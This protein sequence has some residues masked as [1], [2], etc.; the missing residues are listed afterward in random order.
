MLKSLSLK[1]FKC[2]ESLH[3]P[4]APL[5]ML[6]GTNASGK[7]SVLQALVLLHQTMREHEW[8]TRL[9]LNGKSIKL[10]TV[11]DVVNESQGGKIFEIGLMYKNISYSWTF[12]GERNELSMDVEK[13]RIINHAL[14]NALGTNNLIDY[15]KLKEEYPDRIT[16]LYLQK[17]L[18]TYYTLA[19]NNFN[20][21]HSPKT[22]KNN[23]VIDVQKPLTTGFTYIT[24][25]RIGPREVYALEDRQ[26]A[27]AVGP[28]G[29]Y[30]MSLFY[31]RRDEPILDELTLETESRN[32]LFHQVTAR[33][34]QFFPNCLLAVEKVQ[35]ANAVTLRLKTSNETEFHRPMNVGFGLT[36]VLPIVIA[37]LSAQKEDILLIENPEV[38][39]HPAGQALMGQFLAEVANAGV[40]VIL[41]THSDHI[42]NGIRRFVKA[43]RISPEQVALHFF[44][45]RSADT[46]QVVSPQLNAN[47]D[48]DCWPDGF[49][50][51][52]D[53]D[54]NHFAGWD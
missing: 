47:G 31:L 34:Q 22:R 2:F 42:L 12:T 28:M 20:L 46:A 53:K 5:T 41:E 37:A 11:L 10:G 16:P 35:N 24:A 25:E 21:P 40:Q 19:S 38:H 48:L 3:L 14:N 26:I 9:M 44:R 51:Q 33:M 39:L 27:Y 18:P 7:S 36:Q 17:L 29:E 54:L 50:D 6:S 52:F 23:G 49:F 45:A 13:I 4:L 8:S 15:P 30:A 32:T 1:Y 43:G